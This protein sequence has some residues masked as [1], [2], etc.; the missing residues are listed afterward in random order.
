MALKGNTVREQIWNYLKSKGLSN[1]G[2][3][4]LMGN[5]FAESGLNPKNL[6]NTY[7]K[8][9]NH[10]DDSYTK[11]VDDG[12]YDNFVRD[13][14]GYGLAQWTYW[15]RKEKLFNFVKSRKCSI[16]D[17]EAQLDFLMEELGKSYGT[18]L[19]NLKSAISVKEASDAVLVGFEKPKDQ[20][21]SAKDKRAAYGQKYYDEFS[22]VK[23]SEGGNSNMTEAQAR[24][25]V[26]GFMQGWV[27][28]KRS[29]RSHAPI[30]DAY[31]EHKPLPRGYKVTYTDAYCATTTSSAAIKA[32]YTDIIPV[33]CS[34]HYLI[35]QAKKMGIWQE[36]DAHVPSPA[37]LILY[38]WQDS[39][40]G[41]NTGSPD[42]VG[43]VEKVV[44]T[45]ITVI[46]GNMN[47]GVVGRRNL[48]V[49]GRYIRGFICPKYS[50]KAT[51]EAPKKDDAPAA[52]GSFG[53]GDTVRFTGNA[54]YTS[55]YSGGNKKAAKACSARITAISSGK[56]R[57]Y[58]IV[59]TGVYGWVDAKDIGAGDSTIN[60]G[61]TVQ[62][63]GTKH[64]TSSYAGANA[65]S[66]KGGAAK[67]TNIAR[68]NPHP[69]HL[70]SADKGCT[71]NGWVDAKD[72]SK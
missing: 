62:F 12:S 11:A 64:Y 14:A 43:M 6:Q 31:N 42:H 67:V 48:Q 19:A 59:G 22:S 18:I 57:P 72:V 5:L 66:C 27:G 69:Y 56:P 47:G 37:D 50:S 25:K 33:E 30:I 46:E 24:Q 68:N 17:L 52:T 51:A 9:L 3:A 63:N 23:K 8:K 36:N 26:I 2:A 38:D 61:D 4:G 45:T 1:H 7:E 39:G 41:D 28:L 53:I 40:V 10:T 15:S 44:G 54:Q 49:N 71:V 58:H 13:S 34:C 35:E 32:G 55:S 60:V 20:S 65:Y 70:Q 16:G 21:D 29:D